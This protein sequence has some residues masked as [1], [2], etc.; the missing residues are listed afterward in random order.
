MQ[1]FK[2][3]KTCVTGY[4]FSLCL[5]YALITTW[6]ALTG[7]NTYFSFYFSLEHHIPF[8]KQLTTFNIEESAIVAWH[9]L[10]VL[11]VLKLIICTD[12]H[13]FFYT[14]LFPWFTITVYLMV[15]HMSFFTVSLPTTP[16][17]YRHM[18]IPMW[19]SLSLTSATSTTLSQITSSESALDKLLSF[20]DT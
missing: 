1:S 10:K 3:E 17:R 19:K 16:L 8:E 7:C 20:S 5:I 15:Y 13:R 6:A 12:N 11:S 4:H 14:R 9:S 2:Y 18:L